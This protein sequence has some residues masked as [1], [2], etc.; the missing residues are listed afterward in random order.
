[1]YS[2]KEYLLT[3]ADLPEDRIPSEEIFCAETN[4]EITLLANK[5]LD[6]L[7]CYTITLVR[8]GECDVEFPDKTVHLSKDDLFVYLP[9]QSIRISHITDDYRGICL[10]ASEELIYEFIFSRK[11]L[12]ATYYNI[13]HNQTPM[14][15]LDKNIAYKFD[16]YMRDIIGYLHSDNP[17]KIMACKALLAL[18]LIDLIDCQK[19]HYTLKKHSSRKESQIIEFFNLVS[20]HYKE[21][22]DIS[23]YADA[24]E[25]TPIYLSRIVKEIT[26]ITVGDHIDKRIMMEAGWLLQTTNLSIHDIARQLNFSDQASFSKFFKRHKG[27]SPKIYRK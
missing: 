21:N 11:I 24:L 19:T 23:F 2:I 5:M 9:G 10:L 22:H 15:R 1:M 26:G 4:P 16:S 20:E 14:M 3:V 6:S 17:L 25:I 27:I 13:L 7:S 18:L 12:R 8:S